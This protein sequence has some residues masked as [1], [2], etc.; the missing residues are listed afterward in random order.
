MMHSY[1]GLEPTGHLVDKPVQF[2]M[3]TRAAG[4]GQIDV[5]IVNC[6][7]Q[8][9]EVRVFVEHVRLTRNLSL[10]SSLHWNLEMISIK[11]TIVFSIRRSMVTIV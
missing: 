11:H 8:T 6:H 9:E 1:L 7:G 2:H 5:V 3:E 4:L 10:K